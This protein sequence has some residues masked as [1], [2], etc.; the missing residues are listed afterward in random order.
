M[1]PGLALTF[2]KR[3]E[4]FAQSFIF[5]TSIMKAFLGVFLVKVKRDKVASSERVE[6]GEESNGERGHESLGFSG[7]F[8]TERD[9]G[10]IF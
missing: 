10:S 7:L 4:L 8:W 3:T 6:T 9:I 5:Q 2:L 1:K